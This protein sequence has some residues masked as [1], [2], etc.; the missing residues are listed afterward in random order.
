MVGNETLT[1]PQ[2]TKGQGRTVMT[3]CTF[4]PPPTF[5]HFTPSPASPPS[6]TSSASCPITDFDSY[7]EDGHLSRAGS[8]SRSRERRDDFHPCG[9]WY[10][11]V[12]CGMLHCINLYCVKQCVSIYYQDFFTMSMFM[13]LFNGCRMASLSRS[14]F[15][16]E[17][18]SKHRHYALSATSQVFNIV[19]GQG[20]GARPKV[21]HS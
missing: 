9:N 8:V 3:M 6:P 2:T 1:R 14:H 17:N 15:Q 7:D 21:S 10:A 11:R 20:N 19:T 4:L 5:S 16:Q 18:T 13:E 12:V